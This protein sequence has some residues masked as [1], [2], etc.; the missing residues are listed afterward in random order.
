MEPAG[1]AVARPREAKTGFIWL[2]KRLFARAERKAARERRGTRRGTGIV[3]GEEGT[4]KE[5]RARK[6]VRKR[7]KTQEQ[8]RLR[9][10]AAAANQL[11]VLFRSL[12]KSQTLFTLPGLSEAARI[13]VYSSRR[14]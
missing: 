7:R 13:N 12:S 4:E 11:P 9:T 5:K 14:F 10:C 8:R 1:A 2:K 6:S 3:G